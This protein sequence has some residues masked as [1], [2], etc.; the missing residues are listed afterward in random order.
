MRLCLIVFL[1]SLLLPACALAT[2]HIDG[3]IEPGEWKGARHVTDF[4]QTQ[5]MTGKPATWRTEAWILATPEGLAVA[6]RNTQP[7]GVPRTMQQVQRDFDDQVDRNNVEIDFN[8]DGHVGY[9]FTI[10]STGGI[11]DA[12]ITQQ[13]RFDDD[14]DGLWQHAA[15]QD[16]EGWTSEFLI[17]WSIAPMH[18]VTGGKRSIGIYLDRV[19]GSTGE[20]DA[21]PDA[22]FQR[23]RFLSDFKRIEVPAYSQSQFAITPYVSGLYD[24]VRKRSHMREGMD[25]FWKPNGQ[26][27]LTATLNPD[28]GQ[29]ESDDLVVNFSATE[30]YFSD[31]RPFFTENQG[32]FNFS[33]LDDNSALVYTRRVGGP[34]DDGQ[35]VS[36]INAAVKLNGSVG[37]T[38]YGV[39]AADER[40]ADGRTF[41]AA[42][43]THDFGKQSL[44]V[45]ATR[46]ERPF[47]DRTANVLGIDHHWQPTDNLT[48]WTNLVGSDI[49]QQGQST[50]GSGATF[51]ADY[52]MDD[53]WRQQWIAMHFDDRL[54]INDFGYLERNNFDY[55]HWEVR[56]RITDLPTDSRYSS[57]DWQFRIDAVDNDDEHLHLRRQLRIGRSSQLRNGGS[58]NI[59]LNVN[60]AGWDDLLTRGHGA[61]F[62]PPSMQLSYEYETPRHGHWSFDSEADVMTDGLSGNREPGW[63]L[64]FVPTYFIS[65]ALRVHAGLSYQHMPDWLVWQHDNLIG[66]FEQHQIELDAGFDWTID[67]RQELRLK[68]QAIG[69]DARLRGAYLVADNGRAVPSNQPVDDFSVRNLGVQLR[70]RYQLAPLSWLYVV[71][72]RGGYVEEPMARNSTDL[73]SRA[74]GLRQDEQLLVKFSYRFGL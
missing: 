8:G 30:S 54:Q 29:V 66:R 52:T 13:T 36:D 3:H 1:A 51:I 26:F 50:R 73:L 74:L 43:I 19:V 32:I 2:V 68:L 38:D 67:A 63:A 47:L 37:T 20:R 11:Y 53:G 39:L 12:V 58:E 27:Q 55:V 24:N 14:W 31:K 23:P 5:P 59:L 65:D 4:V 57:H 72:G 44:G 15:S 10:S 40:G 46:V 49:V 18:K 42:R 64:S 41:A 16:A 25:I 6:F 28:F 21:W 33:L 22:S 7:P 69:L 17:P 56:K 70:Y 9:N 62:L 71:Y 61:L 48:L 34:S 60:S 35:G 45:L